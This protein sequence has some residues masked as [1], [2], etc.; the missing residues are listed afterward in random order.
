MGK[1]ELGTGQRQGLRILLVD[2]HP[3]FRAGVKTALLANPCVEGVDD[4]STAEEALARWDARLYHVT[5][6]DY[7]LGTGSTGCW[8]TQQIKERKPDHPVIVLSTYHDADVV[9][10]VLTAGADSYLPKTVDKEE[11]D[12]ALQ[13]VSQGHS[14]VHTSVQHVLLGPLRTGSAAAPE[15]RLGL[16]EREKDTL[17]L[18]AR[19]LAPPDIAKELVLSV[20]AVK[21]H[22]RTLYQKFEVSSRADLLAALYAKGLIGR[23]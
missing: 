5:I 23:I 17:R 21:S 19:G 20:N 4:V 6:T 3:M 10:A 16:T 8:L 13:A 14:Y 18:L 12:L 15:D 1:G 22:L 2:D 11:I 9:L 7:Q